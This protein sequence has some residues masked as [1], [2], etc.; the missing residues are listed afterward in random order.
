M[1]IELVTFQ[2]RKE[3]QFET[4]ILHFAS[5]RYNC[6][7]TKNWKVMTVHIDPAAWIDLFRVSRH[8]AMEATAEDWPECDAWSLTWD[9]LTPL[10]WIHANQHQREQLVSKL[11]LDSFDSAIAKRATKFD[12]VTFL[13]DDLLNCIANMHKM[14]DYRLH[15]LVHETLHSCCDWT[16]KPLVVDGVPPSEDKETAAT[17]AAF[18]KH[19]GGWHAFRQLYLL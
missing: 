8:S 2:S 1:A 7:T 18:I 17:L 13:Q 6:K 12:L 16:G 5:D 10:G 9:I 4:D 3:E 19:V 14:P 11:E 15:V